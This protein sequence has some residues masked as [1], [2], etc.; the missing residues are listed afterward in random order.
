MKLALAD[1]LVFCKIRE[2]LGGRFEFAVSGGAP[3]GRDVAEFFWGAGLPIYEGYGLTETS[4]VLTVNAPGAVKLGTVGQADP[5]R[6]AAGS[7]TTAR[8]SPRAPTS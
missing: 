7:P 5:R 2:R 3:L 8:S 4:P 1:K 6:R